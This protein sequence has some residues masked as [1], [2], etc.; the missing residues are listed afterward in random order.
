M[1]VDACV[2]VYLDAVMAVGS[3]HDDVDVDVDL[4]ADRILPAFLLLT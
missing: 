4:L 3:V 1:S 2:R